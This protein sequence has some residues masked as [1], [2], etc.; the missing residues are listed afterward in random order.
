MKGKVIRGQGFRGVLNYV[1]DD[2]KEARIL[3]GNMTGQDAKALAREFSRVRQLR[4][5][6]EKPV[7]HIPLR[8]PEGEDVSDVRWLEITLSF[9]RLMQLSNRPWVIVKHLNNHIH[10]ITS[11]VDYSGKV[12]TGEWEALRLIEATQQIEKLFRLTITPGLAG[13]NRKQVRLTSGQLRKMQREMD[14]GEQPEVLAKVAL[15]ERIEKSIA[16]SNGTFNDFK[17]RLE[18]LGVITRLNIAKTTNHVSGI[19]FE[20]DGV[21]M[22]GSKVARAYS[23]QGLN[24]LLNERKGTG[25]NIRTPQPGI[26]PGPRPINS[27]TGQPIV[28]RVGQCIGP[29][30]KRPETGS[31]ATPPPVQVA[32]S[33]NGNAGAGP[34]PDLLLA[35]LAKSPVTAGSGSIAGATC[36]A[37]GKTHIPRE[38]VIAACEDDDGPVQESDGPT[39]SF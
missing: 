30:R 6:C 36:P 33:D 37:S 21:V 1:L 29:T 15:A 4:P 35:L 16:E 23:W 32:L 7:L 28:G 5:G 38:R 10:L 20:F 34:V 11:R 13:R 22:K 31:V 26:E 17:A 27:R 8:L 14:R 19:S 39:M 9:L 3:G 24:Q 18:K 2:E 25:E 12:W